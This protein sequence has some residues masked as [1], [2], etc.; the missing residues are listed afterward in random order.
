MSQTKQM[1]KL[2]R[3]ASM[4]RSLY[5]SLMICASCV[6][7][8]PYFYAE[9]IT[10][11]D[12]V[13]IDDTVGVYPSSSV[14]DDPQNP[15]ALRGI[16]DE[17]K[18]EVESHGDPV[19]GFY[20]WATLLATQATGEHQ[21]YTALNLKAI[22]DR[23]RVSE[24]H[25]ELVLSL[26]SDGFQAVLDHFP[27]SATYDA[28]GEIPYGLATLAYQAL[29]DLGVA[30]RGGWVLASTPEGA[31]VALKVLDVPSVIAEDEEE[32]ENNGEEEKR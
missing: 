27:E 23:S 31:Q 13:P 4:W 5:L 12:F 2:T 29:I 32:G 14:L 26:A 6:E 19:A 9:K 30:P 25:R 22:Y 17:T 1:I 7:A 8:P 15:F 16:G 10:G 21:Y 3:R 24:E 18:W 11:R 20:A 28:T